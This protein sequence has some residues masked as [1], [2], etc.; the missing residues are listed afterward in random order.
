MVKDRSY[1]PPSASSSLVSRSSVGSVKGVPSIAVTRNGVPLSRNSVDVASA[2][3]LTLVVVSLTSTGV[4]GWIRLRSTVSCRRTR[5]PARR[6]LAGRRVLMDVRL[7]LDGIEATRQLVGDPRLAD[8][9]V[10]VLTTFELDD[11]IAEALRAGASGFLVK[12]I[13]PADLRTAVRV[14]A[15]GEAL[16]SPGATKRLIAQFVGHRPAPADQGRF[17][18]A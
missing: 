9:R 4:P 2:P 17:D 1:R 13:E 10:I 15:G 11:Y 5:R 6:R 7:V 3:G 8:T 16:L 14:M 12:D 18:R